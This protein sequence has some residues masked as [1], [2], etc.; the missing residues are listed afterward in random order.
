MTGP[1]LA[2]PHSPGEP[3]LDVISHRMI[4][5]GEATPEQRQAREKFLSGL[6]SRLAQLPDPAADGAA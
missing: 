6:R 4:T 3:S 1:E 2:A 5:W